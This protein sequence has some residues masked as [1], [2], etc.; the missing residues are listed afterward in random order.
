MEIETYSISLS[1]QGNCDIVDITDKVSDLVVNNNFVEGNV[2]LFAGGSTAGITTIE[3]EP[4][5]LK[6]YPKFF[7]RLA[8]ANINYEHDNTWHDGNGHSH[9]RAS[10]Q[11]ASFTVPFTRARLMLGTWQQIIF[12]DF[13]NRSRKREITVQITGKKK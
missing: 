7:E 9:V 12:V 6:D 8:P 13:D 3:Y 10:I 2:L 1:T 11:G 4:G 5:L